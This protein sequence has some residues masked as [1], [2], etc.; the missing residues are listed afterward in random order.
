MLNIIF[1]SIIGYQAFATESISSG[2]QVFLTN[3]AACHGSLGDGRGPA[4]VAIRDPKPRNFL[5]EELKYGDS[6]EAIFKTITNGVPNTAMPPWNSLSVENRRDVANYI[7]SLVEKQK[8][9]KLLKS[10]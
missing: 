4:A 10:K 5:G 2:R 1:L 9:S 3:C 7:Y 6:K 8:K